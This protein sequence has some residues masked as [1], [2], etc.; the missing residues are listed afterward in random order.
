MTEKTDDC[1]V[2]VRSDDGGT[3]GANQYDC[4]RFPGLADE[5]AL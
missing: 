3:W 5:P 1:L 4:K 2:F